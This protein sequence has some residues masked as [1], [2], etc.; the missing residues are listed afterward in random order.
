M[1][2]CKSVPKENEPLFKIPLCI[3]SATTKNFEMIHGAGGIGTALKRSKINTTQSLA[4]YKT[5]PLTQKNGPVQ[6]YLHFITKEGNLEG[7]RQTQPSGRI[8]GLVTSQGSILQDTG[9]S[10][11]SYNF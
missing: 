11:A 2:F 3:T 6:Q 8:A 5:Q 10:S 4:E 7:N 1:A 9:Y